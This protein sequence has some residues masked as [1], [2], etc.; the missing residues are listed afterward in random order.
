MMTEYTDQFFHGITK[1]AMGLCAQNFAYMITINFFRAQH[2]PICAIDRLHCTNNES[3]DRANLYRSR[4]IALL[5][6]PPIAHDSYPAQSTDRAWQLPC[7]INKFIVGTT[8]S[9][10]S[11]DRSVAHDIYLSYRPTFARST[12]WRTI[13]GSIVHT[14]RSIAVE[15][16][17]HIDTLLSNCN[18]KLSYRRKTAPRFVSLNILLNHLRSFEI[19]LLSR[20][21]V[22]PY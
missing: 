5:R 13:D 16:A 12:D 7:A 21:C 8:W 4:K 9:I 15:C 1:S 17:W 14:T 3:V 20:A 22:S 18:K 6:E 11:A 2:R 10:D 19:T